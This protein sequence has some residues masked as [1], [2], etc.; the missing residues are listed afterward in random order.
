MFMIHGNTG[1]AAFAFSKEGVTQG[2]QLAFYLSFDSWKKSFLQCPSNG[3][4]VMQER[5]LNSL[6]SVG[7]LHACKKIG[8]AYGYF[9]EPTKS[10]LVTSSDNYNE[11]CI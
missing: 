3:T 11:A 4:R 8:P 9:P 10:I 6:T 7:N 1:V 5:E 2:D